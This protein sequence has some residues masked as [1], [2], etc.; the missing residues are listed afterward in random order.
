[1]VQ[2]R[3]ASLRAPVAA[4]AQFH[5]APRVDLRTGAVAAG[6]TRV[7]APLL[8]TDW[9]ALMSDARKAW[10]DSGYVAPI[11]CRAPGE[12]LADAVT[13]SDLDQAL[14]AAGFAMRGVT[15]EVDEN[16]LLHDRE[17]AMAALERLRARG[18]GVMLRSAA[19]CPLP[20]GAA[21]RG[22]FTDLYVDA[23]LDLT[24]FLGLE[25]YDDEPLARRVRAAANAG[26]AVT[27]G[28]LYTL[29]HAPLLIGAGFDRGEG[30]GV[31]LHR[32]H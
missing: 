22:V 32:V 15:I 26:I 2:A 10:R 17:N 25:G 31:N 9:V 7:D 18:W 14:R 13:A 3:T 16:A 4:P 20:F 1:M 21:L 23:P 27:A 28:G 5:I 19:D 11:S 24:P 8:S 6:V 30:P 29:A 12:C